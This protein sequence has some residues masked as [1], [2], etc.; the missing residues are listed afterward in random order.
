MARK[1]EIV[2][3][4][5]PRGMG[6]YNWANEEH[7]VIRY[8][9]QI[10]YNGK[11]ENLSVSGSS[12]KEVNDLMMQKENEIKKMIDLNITKSIT[13]TLESK[14]FDWLKL[15]KLD[16]L[17]GKSYD[18]IESTYLNHIAG[19]DLGRMQ[20]RSITSDHIQQHMKSLKNKNNG[21]TLSYS[22]EKKV[23]ELLNQY[24]KYRYIKEP[25]MNPMIS[26]TK[27]KKNDRDIEK[28]CKQEEL[29]IWDDE[30]MTE[31]SKLAAMP[32]KNGI[33]GYKHGLAI[34]FVMWSFLR[35][36]EAMAL[37]WKDIDFN[38]ETVNVYHQFSRVKDRNSLSNK[39]KWELTTVKY[40]SRRKFKLNK[41]AID[42]LKEYKKRKNVKDDNE[43]IFYSGLGENKPI[44]Y[45]GI[46]NTYKLMVKSANV[47]HNK[48]V[49]IHGLRHS[50]ISYMLRHGV[51]IEVVSKMAGHKSIKV[52][53]EIYYSVIEKQKNDA[54]DKLNEEH[55]IDFITNKEDS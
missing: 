38:E 32:Y 34:I 53:I 27:P 55:Y 39:Y 11:T 23:Y 49:T 19:T 15:Y 16:D 48:N 2:L 10:T 44:S 3:P 46:E 33:E 14:I 1:K 26:V 42:A 6:S 54:V 24:F 36:G 7:T 45:S 25:Y 31:L 12:I 47:N 18:R 43:Y 4:K 21:E 13:G 37:T 30:E 20:E 50:G 9:K 28:E 41:M 8:R 35:I 17:K 5:L 51:P 22:S 29:I 40:N 52:T